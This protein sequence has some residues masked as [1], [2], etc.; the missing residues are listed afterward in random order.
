MSQEGI[1]DVIGTHPEIPTLFIANVGFAIPI[2]NTLELLGAV[3]TAGTNPFRSI[4]SGN[5]ITYQVQLAQAFATTSSTRAG[6][7]SFYTGDFDVDAN[8]FVTLD[9]TAGD[10][11]MQ[12]DA[13]TAPGTNPVTPLASVITVTGGQVA[14][15]TTAN[16]IR[17]NSLAANT[18]TI[19]IQR[20]SNQA[21][22]TIGANGVSHF[23]SA[24]FAVDANGFVTLNS[25]GLGVLSVSGTANRITSTGGQN[26]QID[27]SASYVGQSSITTLGTITTG[28]WN[29]TAIDLALYVTGNLAVS[30][31]NSGTSASASTFWR[32]DGTWATPAGTGVTSVTGTL[33]RIT[34]TGG[35]TP[36]ID[37]SASYVGQSSITTLGTI[38]TGVWNGTAID[39]ALYVT[40]NLAV[41]HLNSGTSASA[42]TFWRG[43]GTWATPA[44]TGV[45]SVTGT[46][47]RITSSGGTT[48]QIDI[49]ATYV[50]QTSITTLG[51]IATGVWQG[52]AVGPTFGGTGQTSYATGDIL[53]AS[54]SNTLSK[55]AATTN[56]FVLTLAAGIP[57]WAA[58]ASSGITTINGDTGSVT[59]STVTFTATGMSLTST[60]SGTATTMTLLATDGNNNTVYGTGAG[61]VAATGQFNQSFGQNSLKAL[62]SGTKNCGIG[63]QFCTAVTTGGNN[64]GVGHGCYQSLITGSYN[65]GVG[66]QTGV[67]YTGSESSNI[68]INSVGTTGQSNVLTIGNGTGTGNQQVNKAVICGINGKTSAAGVAVLVNGSDVLGTTTSSKRFKDN[69]VDMGDTSSLIHKLRPVTFQFKKS[70]SVSDEETKMTQY[71]LIAE[72][73]DDI[74]PELVQYDKKGMAQTVRYLWLIPMLLNEVKK[75]KNEI[76]EL[77]VKVNNG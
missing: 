6:I 36:Q 54:A 46:A 52:T 13:F 74:F 9:A 29:G 7:A 27:I 31:L 14:A 40:G 15:G 50:G 61:R 3:V 23:D 56:G 43:D 60:F 51:T 57:S 35:T 65:C 1:I 38:T 72:E 11:N 47:N 16:V 19:Q 68:D 62:T 20:S 63:Y 32:G 12:V 77:K 71:G 17:T 26:P 8:G 67:N 28:V 59:G 69:I 25:S 49:A 41:S 4:G 44:G 45:T 22:S 18:Y 48:P 21:A 39:L 58:A 55:L 66:D 30:H 10:T 64:A 24:G 34:S 42:S 2:A 37:I 75:L 33:N 73:V 70:D 76:E 5:T 53:Y